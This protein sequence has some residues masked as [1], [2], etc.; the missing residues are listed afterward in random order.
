MR[1][2]CFQPRASSWGI[3]WYEKLGCRVTSGI[4]VRCHRCRTIRGIWRAGGHVRLRLRG[5]QAGIH[6]LRLKIEYG[7]ELSDIMS[8]S[9]AFFDSFIAKVHVGTHWGQSCFLMITLRKRHYVL[10]VYDRVVGCFFV[11]SFNTIQALAGVLRSVV[12]NPRV[13]NLL[14]LNSLVDSRRNK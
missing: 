2:H 6:R 12:C 13:C 4:C 11:P 9:N 8:V 1:Y 10:W 7:R 3:I 5:W 14:V